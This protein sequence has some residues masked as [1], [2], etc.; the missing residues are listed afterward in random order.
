MKHKKSKLILKGVD[1]TIGVP[2][3]EEIH[4]LDEVMETGNYTVIACN[5]SP[6]CGFPKIAALSK[7]NICCEATLQVTSLYTD[8]QQPS[9]KIY[10][11]QLTL[12]GEDCTAIYIRRLTPEGATPWQQLATEAVNP[13]DN[14]THMKFKALSARIEQ[15]SEQI[16]ILN[17]RCTDIANIKTWV[18]DLLLEIFG[19]HIDCM[20]QMKRRLDESNNASLF[21]V[22]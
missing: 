12:S 22:P 15:I 5:V 11:Q 17:E 18:L 14:D 2:F 3:V 19:T 10:G 13:I 16:R 8:N 4:S 7:E 9:N 6:E 21:L 1:K 20:K